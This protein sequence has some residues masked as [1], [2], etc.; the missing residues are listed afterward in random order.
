MSGE[1]HEAKNPISWAVEAP[2]RP[3]VVMGESGQT[4]TYGQLADRA[5]RLTHLLR[6]YGLEA[7]DVVALFIDNTARFHEV[8]WACRLGGFYFV[9]INNHLGPDEAAYILN[10][11]GAKVV[12]ASAKLP[13]SASI[14][15]DLAPWDDRGLRG[16]RRRARHLHS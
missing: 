16:L 5:S 12:V 4:V 10:D 8:T 15:A 9:T 13:A 6:S 7:G 1:V 14:K 3:A 11:S 2:E